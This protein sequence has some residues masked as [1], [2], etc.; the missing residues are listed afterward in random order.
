MQAHHIRLLSVFYYSVTGFL[1]ERVFILFYKIRTEAWFHGSRSGRWDIQS[2]PSECGNST[3]T[4][5]KL[6][7]TGM[8][9][10]RPETLTPDSFVT[11][12]MQICSWG[13]HAGINMVK[14][15]GG[16]TASRWTERIP[17]FVLD[18]CCSGG[19]QYQASEATST[20]AVKPGTGNRSQHLGSS[21]WHLN[22]APSAEGAKGLKY[23]AGEQD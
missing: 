14:C 17:D 15:E 6:I 22:K 10:W 5:K 11:A 12:D 16:C 1:N 13:A 4:L 23:T 19:V 21:K 2:A 9:P 8:V 20:H 7:H 3:L 18:F